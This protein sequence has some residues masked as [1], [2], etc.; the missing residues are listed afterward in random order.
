V[1]KYSKSFPGYS[2]TIS[3]WDKLKYYV[4]P[5]LEYTWLGWIVYAELLWMLIIFLGFAGSCVLAFF[6]KEIFWLL[7][8]TLPIS[9]LLVVLT[10][11]IGL[12]R[13]RFPVEPFLIINA[14]SFY[15]L[16]FSTN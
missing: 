5:D 15:A 6:N 8:K 1:Y 10:V 16:C 4:L 2:T 13:L 14:M 11:G 3:L 12:A 9:A 7:V